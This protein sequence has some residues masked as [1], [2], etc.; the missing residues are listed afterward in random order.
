MLPRD[1]FYGRPKLLNLTHTTV[2]GHVERS[3]GMPPVNADRRQ[4]CAVGA[5]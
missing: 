2:R 4:P 3:L 5:S 1:Q